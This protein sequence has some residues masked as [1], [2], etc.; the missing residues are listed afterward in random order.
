M[1][2]YDGFTK[3]IPPGGAIPQHRRSPIVA[4]SAKKISRDLIPDGSAWRRINCGQAWRTSGKALR[5][6]AD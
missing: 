2:I 1:K 4:A 6:G 5:D 3:K